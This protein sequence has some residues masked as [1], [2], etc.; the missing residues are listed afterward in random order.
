[1]AKQESLYAY[2]NRYRQVFDAGALYWNDPRPNPH[3][4]QMLH[5]LPVPSRCVEFGCGEG[6]Q[7]YLMASYGHFVTAIDLAPTVLYPKR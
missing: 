7:A 4:A 2:E 5:H 1:M 3:L 6:Y